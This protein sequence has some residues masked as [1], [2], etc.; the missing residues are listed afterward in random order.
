MFLENDKVSIRHVIMGSLKN[1]CFEIDMALDSLQYSLHLRLL[2]RR[3]I[4]DKQTETAGAAVE[5]RDFFHRGIPR[6]ECL[7]YTW[8]TSWCHLDGSSSVNLGKER[9]KSSA[10]DTSAQ[11]WIGKLGSNR[12]GV[13]TP[14]AAKAA[15]LFDWPSQAFGG[16]RGGIYTALFFSYT[17]STFPVGWLSLSSFRDFDAAAANALLL[18]DLELLVQSLP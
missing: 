17:Y 18:Y 7:P 8:P 5:R 11:L 16:S 4:G 3:A 13:L 6:F 9:A 10:P 1:K 14:G 15:G 2:R 12:S